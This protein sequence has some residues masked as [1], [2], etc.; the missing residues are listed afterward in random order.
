M[1]EWLDQTAFTVE[2]STMDAYR[3]H[4]DC[5][6]LPYFRPLRLTLSAIEPQHLQRYYNTMFKSGRTDGKGG[7]SANTVRKH[8]VLIHGALK[9]AVN[10]N[11]IPYNPADRVT[12]PR[13]ESFEAGFYNAEQANKLLEVAQGDPLE[14][15]V[16][17]MLFYGLRRSE[18]LGLRWSSVDF[19]KACFTIEKTRVQSKS[20]ID[21]KNRTKTKRS[22][23]SLPLVP[24]I[25]EIMKA[26]KVRQTENRLF[27][28][29]EYVA[30]DFVCKWPDGT[31]FRPDFV[32]RSF[33]R[34]LVHNKLP[35][36]RF[37][38]LRH[39]CASLMLSKGYSL[40]EISEWLGHSDIS[41]TANIYGHL[42]Y[43]QKV[44]LAIGMAG[45]LDVQSKRKT[46]G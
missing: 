24:E 11:M 33:K 5:H 17:L 2:R 46:S 29:G 44:N 34:L 26:A 36:I 38:D 15:V 39:S 19:D 16:V 45:I 1:E 3:V 22:R 30:N 7:L 20:G 32:T 23:R 27:F 31:P 28:G 37:H 25:V 35:V 6:I 21:D 14:L 40:K 12:L 13:V 43:E 10:K 41:T 9:D 8:H 42:E 18:V 4:T